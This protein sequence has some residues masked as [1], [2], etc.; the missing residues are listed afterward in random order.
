MNH[1][2]SNLQKQC[3]HWFKLQYPKKLIWHTPNGAGKKTLRQGA[4]LRSEGLLKGVPDL[5]VPEPEKGFHGAYIEMKAPKKKPTKEQKD[6]LQKLEERG[7]FVTVCDSFEKFE[8]VIKGY[9]GKK[10]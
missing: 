3:V 7:Y 6:M 9:F 5:C 10:I 8:K 1:L 2:E 4:M